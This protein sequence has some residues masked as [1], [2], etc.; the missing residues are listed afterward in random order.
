[1][2]SI[3]DSIES[4]YLNAQI[5]TVI[6]SKSG[7]YALQRAADAKLEHRVFEKKDY[8]N[9]QDMDREIIALL[10]SLGVEYV[11]L[12]GY[13]NILSKDFIDAYRGRIVNIHPSLIPKYCGDGMYGMRVHRAVI[14]N[15]EKVSGASVHYVDEGVDTGDIIAQEM[16]AVIESDT[17]E[18]L[19]ARVL[20]LEHKLLPKTLK[21]LFEESK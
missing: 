1:M 6:A 11:V 17:A 2:Q 13:L 20:E 21:K 15:G 7:V 9:T 16:V 10:Q 12:A 8:L 4:G 19:A 5:K 3:I 14:E 18:T